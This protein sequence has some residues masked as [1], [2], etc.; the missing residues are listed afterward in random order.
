MIYTS[1]ANKKIKYLKKLRQ[2]KYHEQDDYFLVEG[3]DIVGEAFHSNILE[4][5]YLLEDRKINFPVLQNYLSKPVAQYLSSQ[6]SS[7]F[8]FGLCRKKPSQAIGKRVL[9]LSEIQ[10]PGNLGA[11]LRNA[12]AFNIDTVVLHKTC[13]LYHEKTIRSSKG[14]FFNLNVIIDDDLD[15]LKK[16]SEDYQI[17]ATAKKSSQTIKNVVNKKKFVIIMGNEGHGISK[18]VLAYAHEVV[19]IPIAANCESLNVAVASGILLYEID[20]G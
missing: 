19:A 1:K 16:M 3:H 4:E 9:Y 20:K 5:V 6:K 12:L 15:L 10:E 13:D 7:D 2:K 18:T 8:V 17:I 11:M 14:A